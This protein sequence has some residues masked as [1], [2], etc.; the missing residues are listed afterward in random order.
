VQ[1]GQIDLKSSVKA[2][3]DAQTLEGV[4]HLLAD[5]R[6]ISGVGESEFVRGA[7]WVAPLLTES[8]AGADE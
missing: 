1:R 2:L 7:C 5:D 6:A 3:F 8:A 4:L